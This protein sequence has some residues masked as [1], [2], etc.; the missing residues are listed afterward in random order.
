MAGHYEESSEKLTKLTLD[1]H[2]AWMSLKEEIEAMD[3]YQQRID[4][5]D[6]K[7]LR[8]ILRHN[9]DEEKEHAAMLM[10]WIRRNDTEFAKELKDYLFTDGKSI[11]DL[12]ES[13]E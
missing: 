2:R 3:W 1:L 6:D 4:A 12:E 10:E 5:S 7:D 8:E 13:S 9:R 11:T